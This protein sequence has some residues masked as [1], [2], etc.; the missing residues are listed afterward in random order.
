MKAETKGDAEYQTDTFGVHS[1]SVWEEGT[2]VG[3]R[4]SYVFLNTTAV[5]GQAVLGQELEQGM[6]AEFLRV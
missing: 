5:V 6:A 1:I 3:N 4:I 2:E